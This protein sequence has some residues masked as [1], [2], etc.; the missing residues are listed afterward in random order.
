MNRGNL[1]SSFN[2]KF[3]FI[4]IISFA[5]YSII[6]QN[7]GRN[8]NGVKFQSYSLKMQM[9]NLSPSILVKE[10]FSALL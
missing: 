1:F 4:N 8:N 5:F 10:M 2:T 6:K 3:N 7:R 9:F